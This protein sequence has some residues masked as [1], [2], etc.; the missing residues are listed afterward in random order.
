[1]A[2]KIGNLPPVSTLFAA[3]L[4]YNPLAHL[5]PAQRPV[6]PAARLRAA[7][8]TGR[9]FFPRLIAVPFRSGLHA[10]FDFAALGCAIAAVASWSRGKRYVYRAEPAAGTSA[11]S[12]APVPVPTLAPASHRAAAALWL[13]RLV[14]PAAP[15]AAASAPAVSAPAARSGRFDPSPA[16]PAAGASVGTDD[17]DHAEGS[18]VGVD[19][20]NGAGAGPPVS[21]PHGAESSGNGS[22]L[23]PSVRSN[24]DGGKQAAPRR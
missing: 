11:P 13:L 7:V 4:G 10:A 24:G 18:A 6:E 21:A 1:M 5:L 3:F 20:G 19:A 15:A 8:V 16:V 22:R 9:S 17:T 14:A 2:E 12:A 23:P